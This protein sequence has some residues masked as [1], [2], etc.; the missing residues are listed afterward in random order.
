M[1]NN[2]NDSWLTHLERRAALGQIDRRG[3]MKLAAALG[4]QVTLSNVTFAAPGERRIAAG[5]DFIVVGAGSAG[6]AVAARLAEDPSRKVLLI[7]AGGADI[8]RPALT[9]PH[10]WGANCGPDVN[11]G[12]QTTPQRNAY[13][14]VFDWPRGKVLGGS[15]GINAMIWVWGHQAD[16]DGWAKAGNEGWDYA[17]VKPVFQSIE[18]STR[19]RPDAGRGTSGPMHVGAMSR[20][21]PLNEAFFESC[22]QAGHMVHADVNGPVREGAGLMDLSVKNDKRFSVAHGYLLPN[23][24]RENFTLL[25]GATVEK[26]LFDGTRCTGVRLRVDGQLRDVRADAETILSAGALDSP[27]LLLQSGIGDGGE[28]RKLGI[29]AVANLPGVGQNLHDHLLLNAFV[30]ETREPVNQNGFRADSHVFYRT[31][32]KAPIP[33]IQTIFAPAAL[34]S[35]IERNRGYSMLMGLVSPQSRGSVKLSA[36]EPGS[37]LLIDPGYLSV[38]SDLDALVAGAERARDIGMAGGFSSWRKRDIG[39]LPPDKTS[40]ADYIRRN[41]QSYWHPVGTCAMGLHERAV[42]NPRLQV[43]GVERLRVADASVMP[44]ITTGNTNAPSIMIGERAARLILAK[45]S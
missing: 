14:R 23:L 31:S 15:S 33:D 9:S 36:A 17:S 24:R 1:A 42:V 39:Q 45:R 28:L 20:V 8:E 16:F 2:E 40:I 10:T 44:S 34:T 12:Y 25:T 30:A 27:R 7:E 4:V 18:T 43:H 29:K 26:L 35:T 21:N 3:F 38:Q 32:E 41:V 11:W 5:Y 13:N 37:P 6:C 22:R 19:A